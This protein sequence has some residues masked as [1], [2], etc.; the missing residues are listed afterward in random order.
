MFSE[1]A[2]VIGRGL[3]II[4]E[5]TQK[6]KNDICVER[7]NK[8]TLGSH[9]QQSPSFSPHQMAVLSPFQEMV[10]K[11]YLQT[12]YKHDFWLLFG[13]FFSIPDHTTEGNWE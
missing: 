11:L 3:A 7:R 1:E 8:K 5:V 6:H 2:W 13:F 10:K 12:P 9:R 4:P